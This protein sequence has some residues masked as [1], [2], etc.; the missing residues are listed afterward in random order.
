MDC[1]CCVGLFIAGVSDFSAIGTWRWCSTSP[2]LRN[3][4]MYYHY[5][6]CGDIK[7]KGRSART[8]HQLPGSPSVL[9]DIMNL[10]NNNLSGRRCS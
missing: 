8:A 9:K 6:D 7:N 3:A 1:K 4:M 10:Q 2:E 5:H